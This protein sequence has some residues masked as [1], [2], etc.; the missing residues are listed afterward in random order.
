VAARIR[1]AHRERY[2]AITGIAPGSRLRRVVDRSGQ[3]VR[4]PPSGVVLSAKLA[5]VLGV[6]PGE[7]VSI[8]VLEGSRP[9]RQVPVTGLVD[10]LLGLS[11]YMDLDALH[12]LMREGDVA[13]G[14]LLLID[15]SQEPRLSSELKGLPAV[16]G[17][18]FKRAVLQSFRET[19]AANMG[20][21]IFINVVFASIIA[22]GVVYNAAR[23]SLSER[24]RELASLRVLGFTRAEISLILMGELALITL[25]ALPIGGLF[26]YGL[27]GVIV[28]SI[29]SEVYRFPL[30]VSSQ[31]VAWSFL[32]IIA[33][34]VVSGLMVRRRL[35][36]LDLVAVLK[37]RE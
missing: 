20:L 16:A 34:A 12:R 1:S 26:G 30:Y 24:S 37:I 13:T 32:G 10:D 8:E 4:I 36:A 29:E 17:A 5:E 2:L 28:Q 15:P 35:D 22:F 21:S 9:Q 23:I 6:A 11:I 25:A 7:D 31:S 18:G 19:M 3:T 14:A 27:A 33:A